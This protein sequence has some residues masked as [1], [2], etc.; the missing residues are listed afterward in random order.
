MSVRVNI[1]SPAMQAA[2]ASDH[3][4]FSVAVHHHHQRQKAASIASLPPSHSLILGRPYIYCRLPS[5]LPSPFCSSSPVISNARE[6]EE[7]NHAPFAN[8]DC[9]LPQ[10]R[11]DAICRFPPASSLTSRGF[12][13]PVRGSNPIKMIQSTSIVCALSR[14]KRMLPC[15]FLSSV[16]TSFLPVADKS[17]F[18]SL[19]PLGGGGLR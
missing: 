19:L 5:F 12:I 6:E 2:S 8:D 13:P 15:L 4:I 18:V 3:H 11:S 7:S 17:L 1:L 16:L 10:F 9:P 14:G